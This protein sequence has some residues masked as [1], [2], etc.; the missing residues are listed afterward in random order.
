MLDKSCLPEWDRQ[1]PLP[2]RT[3]WPRSIK[4]CPPELVERGKFFSKEV[5]QNNNCIKIK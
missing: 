2:I 3:D 4:N 1:A 5:F